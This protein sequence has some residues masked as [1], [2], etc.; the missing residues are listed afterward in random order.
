MRLF[1]HVLQQV[2]QVSMRFPYANMI[3]F[4][5]CEAMTFAGCPGTWFQA[6]RRARSALF[7]LEQSARSE[8][9]HAD[10]HGLFLDIQDR[11][12]CRINSLISSLIG[13]TS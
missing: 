11:C 13:M 3:E 1:N 7:D 2:M 8:R 12:S 9:L 10:R 4:G 6:L 5:L